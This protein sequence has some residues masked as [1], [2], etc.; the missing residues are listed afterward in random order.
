MVKPRDPMYVVGIELEGEN[1]KINIFE[2][3]DPE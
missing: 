3:E 2:G 1:H